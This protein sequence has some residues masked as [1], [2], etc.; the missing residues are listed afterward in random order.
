MII[1]IIL[2]ISYVVILICDI[3]LERVLKIAYKF[4]CDFYDRIYLDIEND[5]NTNLHITR[6]QIS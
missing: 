2:C 1:I 3:T 4:H 5:Y 6:S